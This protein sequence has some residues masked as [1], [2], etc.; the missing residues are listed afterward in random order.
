MRKTKRV[1]HILTVVLLVALLVSVE[2]TPTL[3][4]VTQADI[5]ALKKES[6]ELESKKADLEKQLDALADDK[7][8][9]LQR[10]KLLDQQETKKLMMHCG[11]NSVHYVRASLIASFT[12]SVLAST[13]TP[14]RPPP[15]V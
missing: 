8:E 5:D 11:K 14:I 6:M 3:A 15:C 4:W 13:K 1:F 12:T 9:V 2:I 10:R 7:A